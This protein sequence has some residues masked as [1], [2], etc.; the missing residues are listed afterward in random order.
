MVAEGLRARNAILPPHARDATKAGAMAG[1]SAR[2]GPA[3]RR[4]LA[5]ALGLAPRGRERHADRLP[6]PRSRAQASA[7]PRRWQPVARA[8]TPDPRFRQALHR[9]RARPTWQRRTA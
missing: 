1:P 3:V 8:R 9:A 4:M 5:P 2:R 6:R 7:A